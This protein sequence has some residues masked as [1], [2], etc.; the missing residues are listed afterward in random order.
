METMK[1]MTTDN[2]NDKVFID[3]DPLYISTTIRTKRKTRRRINP[4]RMK[5]SK[6][7]KNQLSYCPRRTPL[8]FSVIGEEHPDCMGMN[9]NRL[10]RSLDTGSPFSEIPELALALALCLV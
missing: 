10:P 2:D 1:M 7:E 9:P 8:I 4:I 3:I 6:G 5:K